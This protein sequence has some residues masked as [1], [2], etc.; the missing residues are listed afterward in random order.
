MLHEFRQTVGAGGARTI[1][2]SLLPRGLLAL[3]D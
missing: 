2:F 1:A 3:A